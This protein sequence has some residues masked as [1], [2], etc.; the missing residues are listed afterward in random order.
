MLKKVK[1]IFLV[2]I[3]I[4]LGL[5]TKSQARITASDPTITSGEKDTVTITI[6]S[7]EPIASGSISVSSSGGLEFVKVTGGT[8]K[9]STVAFALAENKTTGIATYTFKVPT[10]TSTTSYKVTFTSKDMADENG[11]PVNGS[12]ATSTVT[13]KAKEEP[14]PPT[15]NNGGS[16]NNGG[17]TA[18]PKE[19]TFTKVNETVYVTKKV[20]VR[21]SYSTSSKSLGTLEVGTSLTRTGK[22]SNG[23]SRVTY[24]GKEAYINA[25]YLSTKKPEEKPAEEK[26]EETSTEKSNNKALKSLTVAPGELTPAFDAETTKYNMQVE[27]GITEV[28]IEALAEDEKATVEV[29][30]NKDL[31]LGENEVIIKV[32]AED[33]TVRTYTI[34]V[35]RGEAEYEPQLS[36]LDVKNGKLNPTFQADVYSY[37]LDLR[38]N[39]DKLDLELMT[40][41]EDV[42]YEVIGNEKIQDGSVVKIIV[43][44]GEK[45]ADGSVQIEYKITVKK[46]G[47]LATAT[48]N[49]ILGIDQ[50]TFII[51][52]TIILV[53][54]GIIALFVARYFTTKGESKKQMEAEEGDFGVF[55]G[56]SGVKSKEENDL[57]N[58]RKSFTKVDDDFTPKNDNFDF[59]NKPKSPKGKRFM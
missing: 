54:A 12:S 6:N 7:Q 44:T 49:T 9:G 14:K 50:R 5:C 53:T 46:N 21:Q 31:K 42:K 25:S 17:T 45:D 10:V 38:E 35:L 48:N 4:L 56:L 58:M 29:T 22:G 51:I 11:A 27:Q 37:E 2:S 15:T 8:P 3:F 39:V 16:S 33:E 30:G 26:P 40:S 59:D 52:A 36:M 1:Y 18:K 13:V 20:N 32:T 43:Y 47:A 28:T 24:N 41:G 55:D 19:P 23:W 34:I 57:D